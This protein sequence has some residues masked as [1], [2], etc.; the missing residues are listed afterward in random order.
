LPDGFEAQHGDA[1]REST[2]P[3]KFHTKQAYVELLDQARAATKQALETVTEADLDQPAPEPLRKTF[4]TVGAVYLLIAEHPLMHAGQFV[5][6]RRV[7]GK[8]VLI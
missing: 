6:V 1:A 2:D 3:A 5:P 8:P 4:P 7:L